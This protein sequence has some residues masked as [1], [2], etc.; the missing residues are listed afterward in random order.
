MKKTFALFLAAQSLSNFGD[1]LRVVAITII[2]YKMTGSGLSAGLTV[3]YSLIPGILLSKLAGRLGDMLPPKYILIFVELVRSAIVSLFITFNN[4]SIIYIFVIILS[5]LDV[6]NNPAY[7]KVSVSLVGKN[8]VLKGNSLLSGMNGITNILGSSIAAITISSY[9]YNAVF[10]LNSILH[11]LSAVII[12]F[13][14]VEK[15]IES[16]NRTVKTIFSNKKGFCV[17][18]NDMDKVMEVLVTSAIISFGAISINMSF[19]PFAFDVLRVTERGWGLIMSIFYTA[20]ILAMI[21]SIIFGEKLKNPN[22]RFAYIFL[23]IVSVI[24][25]SYSILNNLVVILLLQLIEGISLSLCGILLISKLQLTFRTEYL[26]TITGVS[27]FMNNIGKLVGTGYAYL[28]IRFFSVRYV[29]AINSI[30]LLIYVMYRFLTTPQSH[31]SSIK[32]SIY[33]RT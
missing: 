12:V 27:D 2:L 1:T 28:F 11:A 31:F 20:N 30:I 32:N 4:T 5:S 33:K 21:I 25:F 15:S 3:F 18:Y 17:R 10:L 13:L 7:R 26:S 6:I 14:K 16:S 29:F 8:K 9:G 23:F 24:W 19:Y 22:I